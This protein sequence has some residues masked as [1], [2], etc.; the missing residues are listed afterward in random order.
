MDKQLI[1]ALST[2]IAAAAA[3]SGQAA[4]LPYTASHGPATAVGGVR[5]YSRDQVLQATYKLA[6][7][8][9]GSSE[10]AWAFTQLGYSAGEAS[11]MSAVTVA[12]ASKAGSY[13]NFE[14]VIDG[15]KSVS[16]NLNAREMA[17]LR[18]IAMRPGSGGSLMGLKTWTGT[19]GR[20]WEGS[21]SR[22]VPLTG[23]IQR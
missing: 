8:P 13:M 19:S 3:T 1:A 2:L 18:T 6:L 15:K 9:K 7:S 12:L 22:A 16:V 23:Q 5:A 21:A 20:T 11:Q 14:S 4:E 10:I 17:L